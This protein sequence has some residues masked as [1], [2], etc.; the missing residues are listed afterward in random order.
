MLW[1]KSCAYL[2]C[3]GGC[4]TVIGPAGYYYS[5]TRGLGLGQQSP[6]DLWSRNECP[7]GTLISRSQSKGKKSSTIY[8]VDTGNE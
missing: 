5:E 4:D 7:K 3:A 6:E 1:H 2:L 8:Q